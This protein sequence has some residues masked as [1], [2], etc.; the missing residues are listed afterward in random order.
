MLICPLFTGPDQEEVFSTSPSAE[1]SCTRGVWAAFE[2]KNLI[3]VL[4]TEGML[5][6]AANSS[7]SPQ[8]TGLS[9]NS[10]CDGQIM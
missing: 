3:V 1:N 8:S 9:N 5:G 10:F 4:D 2:P 7:L 6:G